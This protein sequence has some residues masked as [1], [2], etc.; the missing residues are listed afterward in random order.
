M[1]F[2][3]CLFILGVLSSSPLLAAPGPDDRRYLSEEALQRY[4]SGR[5]L[6]ERGDRSKAL[7]EYFRA[8]FLDPH[9]GEVSRRVS[10][11]T[12]RMGDPG[13]SLEF[14]DR[15]LEEMP[16]DPEALWLKGAALINLGRDADAIVVLTEAVSL[17]S[18]RAEYYRTLARAAERTDRVEL[19]ADC[20]RHVVWLDE[21]DGEAWFQLAASEAR[22]GRFG[23]ADTAMT[24]ATQLDPLRPGLFFLQGWIAEGLGRPDEA[25]QDY[26][27]HLDVHHEDQSTR[28]RLILLLAQRKRYKE[29]LDEAH[30]L[31]AA[32][33][34]DLE[35][36]ELEAE[37]SFEAGEAAQG[38]HLLDQMR[39]DFPNSL[40]ALS[41]RIGVLARHGRGKVAVT[42]ADRWLAEH[43][44]DVRARLMAAR[45]RE[46]SGDLPAAID[47]LR[48]AVAAAPDSLAPRVLL[49]QA[50]D[51][52]GRPRDAE[53][54]WAESQ[55]RFPG[56]SS[57]SLDLALCREKLGDLN[58]A[59]VA[60]RDVLAREPENPVALNF[61]GYLLADHDRNLSE[62]V[63]LILKALALEPDNAAFIDSLGWAYFRLG[64]LPEARANLER[65]IQLSGGDPIIYEHLG[66]VY[67]DLQLKDLAR[68]QY[69]KSLSYDKSNERVRAKLSSIR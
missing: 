53:P 39:N 27:Q 16:H 8:L 21:E 19:E 9:A 17:D 56:L 45:A 7:D 51:R 35:A 69:K 4:A 23:A 22:Q 31:A 36:R 2:L 55:R 11:V 10:D 42:E 14:A 32:R 68:D 50:Y 12:A 6:E 46:M 29:A 49:A 38:M 44:D 28:R 62:A 66:D 48:L 37:L 1:R 3:L 59:E 34:G 18:T 43:P 52:A 58:G 26:R 61:L 65:A 41:A 57:V 54:V 64:K 30:T 5:L 20:Y 13:R 67:R 63:Q 60:V 40:D 47:Q 33:P 24:M 25:I 15:A